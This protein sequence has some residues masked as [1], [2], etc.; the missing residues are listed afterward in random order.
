MLNIQREEDYLNIPM[1]NN[2]PSLMKFIIN[3]KSWELLLVLTVLLLLSYLLPDSLWSRA[4]MTSITISY[5]LIW[6]TSIE[7]F[8]WNRIEPKLRPQ[9]LYYYIALITM[10]LCGLF[11]ILLQ[12]FQLDIKI[13]AEI[14][15]VLILVVLSLL[16]YCSYHVSMLIVVA[17]KNRK[18]SFYEHQ[19]E[20]LLILVFALGFLILQPRI[21]KLLI[22]YQ[23]KDK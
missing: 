19:I 7:S 9:R 15:S 2:K 20:F 5:W 8:L 22:K 6:I 13:D 17:E 4:L 16:F 10:I 23:G 3:R 18:A 12:A 14:R 21:N 11:I 1:M